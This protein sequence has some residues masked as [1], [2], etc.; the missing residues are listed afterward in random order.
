MMF[1]TPAIVLILLAER[2]AS[3]KLSAQA[4]SWFPDLAVCAI[5]DIAA[6]I[7]SNCYDNFDPKCSCLVWKQPIYSEGLLGGLC[8]MCTTLDEVQGKLYTGFPQL[9][10]GQISSSALANTY[11][12]YDVLQLR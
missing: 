5:E 2:V 12:C 7:P 4:A 10:R 8:T 3:Q 6:S 9:I 11:S 1:L